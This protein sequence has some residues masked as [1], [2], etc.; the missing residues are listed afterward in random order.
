VFAEQPVETP[1][2]Y[3]VK[4]DDEELELDEAELIN[5]YQ[6]TKAAQK[7]FQEAADMRKNVEGFVQWARNNPEAALQQ[8]GISPRQFAEEIFQRELELEMMTP[9]EKES[10]EKDKKFAEYERRE[11]EALERQAQLQR[12][13]EFATVA[14][15][16]DLKITEVLQG[17]NLKVTPKIMARIGEMMLA[18]MDTEGKAPDVK[19]TWE[20]VHS[21][22]KNELLDF[23]SALST[24]DALAMLPNSLKSNLRKHFANQVKSSSGTLPS[25]RGPAPVSKD[26]KG[27]KK[28]G[29]KLSDFF[30]SQYY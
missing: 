5:G 6:S 21:D 9:E 7:R 18:V 27:Q 1:K 12:E 14:D 16:L 22:Y 8:I 26:D 4:I 25:S 19:E 30:G 11:K 10:K 28:K 3:K 13:K 17:S 20:R 2:R 15:E 29:K 24:E 23:L